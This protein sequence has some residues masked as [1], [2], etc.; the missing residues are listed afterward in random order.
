MPPPLLDLFVDT[1]HSSEPGRLNDFQRLQTSRG[2]YKQ[3][4]HT[5]YNACEEVGGK[6]GPLLW[7]SRVDGINRVFFYLQR[8]S[9]VWERLLST[10]KIRIFGGDSVY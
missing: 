10:S 8:F 6:Y 1:V 5:V 9:G 7:E 3:H 2:K 4:I